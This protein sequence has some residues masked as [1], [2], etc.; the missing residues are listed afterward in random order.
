[1]KTQIRNQIQTALF[2]VV[3]G[4]LFSWSGAY[5]DNLNPP[6]YV[7][8]PLSV[9]A[10]WQLLPGSTILNLTQWSSVD[11]T[12]PTTILYPNFTPT[13]QIMPQNGY[14]Q[15]QLPNWVDNLPMKYMR[16]QL[17]WLND[18]QPPI[19]IFSQALDGVN[20]I[21][22]SITFVSP[23]QVDAAGIK[24]YQYYDFVFKPNPDFERINLQMSPNSVLSQVVV[25]TV[26][27]PE[28]C[29]NMPAWSW[30]FSCNE[31]T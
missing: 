27:T 25:D 17:T 2:A 16:V 20:S 13:P 29:D 12:D 15:F 8:N 5:G 21:M 3:M 24:A 22:G 7:G 30:R 6:S 9:N 4:V 26:S 23:V 28:T 31:K 19:S 1:M 11:D 14:Y 18:L 10:E